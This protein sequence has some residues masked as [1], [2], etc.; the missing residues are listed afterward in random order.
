MDL[1]RAKSWRAELEAKNLK[2]VITNGC[3]DILHRGHA[4]YLMQAR[5]LGAA[6]LVLINSDRSVQ[7]LKG[8]ARPIIN[9]YDRA[10]MLCALES[11]DSVVMFDSQRCDDMF[12]ELRPDIYVKGGDYTLETINP[13]ERE[14]LQSVNTDIRFLPFVQGFS[15][16]DIVN[17]LQK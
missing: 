6:L 4:E 8:P 5:S 9:E 2:L 17:K 12:I 15:T 10:Y 11:V 13:Q 16:T 7:E 3:F 1:S 14:A